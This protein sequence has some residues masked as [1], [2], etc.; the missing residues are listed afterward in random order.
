VP[1]IREDRPFRRPRRAG[2]AAAAAAL[3]VAAAVLLPSTPAA[4]Q[5]GWWNYRWQYRRSATVEDVP[6]TGLPGDEVAVVTMPTA[7]LIAPDGRDIR[8][9]TARGKPV[10]HRVLMIGPGDRV[11]LA[12][13][14]RD[15]TTRYH[16]Y[17][18]NEKAEPP[19][20]ELDIRRGVLLET[21]AYQGGGA[22]SMERIRRTFEKARPLIGRRFLPAVFIGHNPFGPRNRLCSRF[23]GALVC[24]RAGEYV[25]ATSSRDAT[26]LLIDGKEVVDNGGFHRPQRRASKTGR[27]KLSK[28]LHELTVYHVNGG[29]DPI[30]VAAWRPPGSKRLWKIPAEAFAPIR[31]AEPG[32]L[33]RHEQRYVAD[34]LIEHAGETFLADEYLQRYVF[35][36]SADEG[37]KAKA[38]YAWDFG[39]GTTGSG[40]RVE[41][42]YLRNGPARV[43]LTATVSG[44]KLR[45][46]NTVYVTRPWDRVT[47]ASLDPI[48]GHAKIVAG[49][50][51]ARLDAAC[52]GSVVELLRRGRRRKDLLRAGDALVKRDAAPAAVLRSA[53]PTYADLLARKDPA[54]AVAVLLKAAEMTDDPAAGADLTVR[55]GRA[56]LDAGEVDKAETIFT[57]AIEKYAALTT[58]ESIR[59]AR[60]GL[61]DVW[62][63]RGEYDKALAA[64]KLAGPVKRTAYEKEVVRKGDL[65]RHAEA[66]LGTGKLH[67]AE[68]FLDRWEW[69]FPEDRLA[70]FSTLLRVRLAVARRSPARAAELAERLVRV[71]PRSNYAPELLKT[72]AEAYQAQD[73]AD[74][75]R[76]TLERI[77]K[78]YPESPLAAEAKKRL[79]PQ[80]HEGHEEK[81]NGG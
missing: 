34:F 65:A 51:F 2:P 53:V 55:A 52:F 23:T 41:H 62:R 21:W 57:Q 17:F 47:E 26:F 30:A 42:V 74:L 67:D 40:R 70:G 43:K 63:R 48:A 10:G 16:V 11:R 37:G 38:E 80:G 46:V 19:E 36:A 5:G 13:A 39:D 76:R 25:F 6:A 29:G 64:Y 18:G 66:Y 72:A 33:S 27:I 56:A 32:R 50:D 24:E 28:G 68:D 35:T 9:T 15:K 59:A 8:V 69:E 44:R 60:V 31:R 12:F 3:A 61:G 58:D 79:E 81:K 14:L 75:A 71:N 45:R 4:A 49:Y 1:V 20:E 73:K 7:G 78:G 54:Q 22:G 77:V